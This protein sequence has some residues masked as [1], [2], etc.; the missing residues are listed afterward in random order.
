M[1]IDPT[2]VVG[3]LRLRTGDTGDIPWLSD[4]VYNV[5]YTEQDN[6]L[7]RTAQICAQYILAMLTRGTKSQLAQLQLYDNQVYEQYRDFLVLTVTNP[8]FMTISPIA[9]GGGTDTV[10]PLI[11]FQKAWN[12]GWMQVTADEEMNWWADDT[13]SGWQEVQ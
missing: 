9:F 10:N 13:S 6:N 3:K 1:V 7:N 5:T 2:T 4:D 12:A 8:A 11:Q